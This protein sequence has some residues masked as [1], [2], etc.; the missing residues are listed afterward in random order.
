MAIAN[1]KLREQLRDQ[2]IRDVLTGLFNRRY[3]LETLRRELARAARVKQSVSILSIDIDHFKKFNDNHG[4][5]AGDTVLRAF[6]G[7]LEKH[8]R[9]EDVPCRF[10]GEE[11]VVLLPGATADDAARRAD[12]LRVEVEALTLRY[13]DGT[14]PRIT[15]SV[16]VAEFPRSGDNPET[17]LKAADDALY[18]AKDNGRN[19]VEIY[20]RNAGPPATSNAA[21]ALQHACQ[22]ALVE[23][24]AQAATDGRD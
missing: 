12:S 14:L 9:E 10:G 3:M 6:G 16:G 1:V 23:G 24:R 8:F 17:V 21:H 13:L 18:R 5:D 4:H 11:F 2:S 19:R 22:M 20:S 7:C 15:I